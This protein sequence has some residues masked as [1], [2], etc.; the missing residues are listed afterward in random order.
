MDRKLV[1]WSRNRSPMQGTILFAGHYTTQD[2]LMRDLGAPSD[3]D[4]SLMSRGS[5]LVYAKEPGAD[6]WR[7]VEYMVNA[8]K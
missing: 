4:A 1:E 3:G 8:A 2:A 5:V 7:L 6:A